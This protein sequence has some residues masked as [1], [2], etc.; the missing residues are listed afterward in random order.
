MNDSRV[1]MWNARMIVVRKASMEELRV[2]SRML[3]AL[4][5]DKTG[6]VYQE[7]VAKFGIPD[8]YVEKAFSEESMLKAARE[9][10]STFYLALESN[11]ILGFAQVNPGNDDT[12]EL[13]RIVVFPER[14]RKGNRDIIVA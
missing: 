2:L 9:N 14:T 12:V 4:I 7:N 10:W 3:L 6:Q 11:E 13:H 1:E 5:R 8:E